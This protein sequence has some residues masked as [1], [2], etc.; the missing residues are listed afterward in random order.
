MADLNQQRIDS[1][2][3]QLN[4]ALARNPVS[5]MQMAMLKAQIR[6]LRALIQKGEK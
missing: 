6:D 4:L 1:L 2:L 3:S 5:A